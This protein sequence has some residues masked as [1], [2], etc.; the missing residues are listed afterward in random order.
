[1][2]IIGYTY[3]A[4]HWTPEA[5]VA[6]LPTGEGQAFDGWAIAPGYGYV[7]PN[8][9][10]R[11]IALAFGIDIDDEHSFDSDDF[12][13]PIYYGSTFPYE[14]TIELRDVDGSYVTVDAN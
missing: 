14:P 3:Q 10:I 6:A 5:A 1:M 2:G 4:E 8:V 11:E 13:K 9:N 7:D 12:P